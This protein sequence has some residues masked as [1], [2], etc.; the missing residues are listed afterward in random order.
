MQNVGDE[1]GTAQFPAFA[2][3]FAA[4]RQR[5]PGKMGFGNLLETYCPPL[6][7]SANPAGPPGSAVNWTLSYE[8]Y[9]R[10]HTSY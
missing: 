9:V 7:L 3:Q 1:P 8:D 6:S 5:A 2:N 4:I 10:T